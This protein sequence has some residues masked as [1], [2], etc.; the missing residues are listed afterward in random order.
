[1]KTAELNTKG[2][3]SRRVIGIGKDDLPR[4]TVSAL[5]YPVT[6]YLKLRR[7]LS[8]L[9]RKLGKDFSS[10]TLFEIL[11]ED[12]LFSTSQKR[13]EILAL[14]GVIEKTQPKYICEI[15]TASGGTLFLLASAARPEATLISIDLSLAWAR[16]K[17]YSHFA[18]R[19]QRI[20]QIRGDSQSP[21]VVR[22][23]AAALEG[24]KLDLLFIDGDHSYEGV[25]ADFENYRPY[26]K[27][28]GFIAFHDIVPDYQTRYGT[29]TGN[30][31]GG[32]PQFWADTRVKYRHQEFIDDPEQDG[33]GIGLIQL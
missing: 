4:R 17:A 22:Q 31:S 9:R 7:H 5:T 27:P 29:D 15:G 26:V 20:I 23:A 10:K 11:V 28:G 19:A 16:A 6:D 18:R 3:S 32:V 13:A 25:K 1:M 21:E 30:Y 2:F 12:K 33:Y 24:H 8:E 14:L